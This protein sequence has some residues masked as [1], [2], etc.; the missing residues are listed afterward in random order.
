MHTIKLTSAA[1]FDTV[2]SLQII[3]PS[4]SRSLKMTQKTPI[5][6]VAFPNLCHQSPRPETLNLK[7]QIFT[8][9]PTPVESITLKKTNKAPINGNGLPNFRAGDN[10]SGNPFSSLLTGEDAYGNDFKLLA[11][12]PFG[13]DT[14]AIV[15]VR[16]LGT[17]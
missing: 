17:C 1:S 8:G 5:A 9:T 2:T 16:I 10:S 15:V 4:S 7:P 14:E 12:D 11:P 13:Q 3:I 6:V